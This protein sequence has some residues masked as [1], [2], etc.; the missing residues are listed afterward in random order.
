[1]NL[2]K[3]Q[4]TGLEL[5]SKNRIFTILNLTTSVNL[6][7]SKLDASVYQNPYNLSLTTTIPGQNNFSWSANMLANFLLSKTLSGQITG[8]YESPELVAQG[9]EAARYSIDLGMRKT[10]MDRKLSVS[11]MAR[12]ILNSNKHSSTTSGAGFSQ[13]SE[14]F[15]HGR[16]VGVTFSYNFGN[17]KPKAADM[18]KKQSSQDMN[19]EGGGE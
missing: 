18:K 9:T 13:T 17:M 2:S 16:M 14:T 7:Y 19:M 3:S 10:F 15:F 11:L 8:E 5:V 6:Y 4:N 1:M 12:D